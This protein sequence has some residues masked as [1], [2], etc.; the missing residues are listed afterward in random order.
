M[1]N[2]RF[3]NHNLK[4]FSNSKLFRNWRLIVLSIALVVV[5][6]VVALKVS[7]ESYSGGS[8]NGLTSNIVSLSNTLTTDGYGS[9]TNT[10]DWGSLWNRIV[11]A[12]EWTPSG[13][14]TASDVISGDTYY[15]NSRTQSTGAYPAPG[16]CSTQAYTDNNGNATS[17][18]NCSLTWTVP[19]GSPTGT[20]HYD[21][22]TGLT[23]SENLVN[24]SG[25]IG[26]STSTGSAWTYDNT[27][28]N[29]VAV[30]N[31][32]ALQLCTSLGNGWRLPTQKEA[33]Q[34]YVDGAFFN[35]TNNA[36]YFWTATDSSGTNQWVVSI[37]QGYTTT[38]A[39]G[40]TS[41]SIYV[42]CVTTQ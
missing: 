23:W 10:P 35:L 28:T 19:S 42:R 1:A 7:A 41:T 17:T 24:N 26:F 15:G 22:R 30:G 33:M 13:N 8:D 12:S 5:S 34:A 18:T 11:T 32:T 3:S 31:K 25:T 37:S 6:S 39:F 40:T 36:N 9:T 29:N 38:Y 21:S 27:G 16:P 2:N 14:A 4:G 20:D